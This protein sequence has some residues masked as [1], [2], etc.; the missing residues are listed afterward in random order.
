MVSAAREE[1]VLIGGLGFGEEDVATKIDEGY[2]ILH[3]G[4]T[5]AAAA[6]SLASWP[7]QSM[8]DN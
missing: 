2:Q 8:I 5:T 3:V 6:E 1:D 7:D 4:S